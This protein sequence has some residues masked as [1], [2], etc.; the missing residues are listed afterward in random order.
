MPEVPRDEIA[1][2]RRQPPGTEPPGTEPPGTE[3]PGPGLLRR[4][5]PVLR[6]VVGLGIV[7][8]G[9][10]GP[11]LQGL[12]AGRV[13]RRLR[14]VDWWWVPPA[15]AV[16]IGSYVCFAAMQYE[17]LQAGKLRAPFGPLVKVS[18]GAQH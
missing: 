4:I 7:G 1:A 5:W 17:L 13:R 3:P 12:G 15:F 6:V 9:G 18:F 2:A 16:E 11:L 10:V 8:V 14:W